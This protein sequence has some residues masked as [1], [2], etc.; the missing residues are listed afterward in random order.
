MFGDDRYYK[1][2]CLDVPKVVQSPGFYYGHDVESRN[3]R[4]VKINILEAYIWTSEWFR[5]VR[6]FF[7][8]TRR[9]PEPP[10]ENMGLIGP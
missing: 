4:Y 3:G 5:V 7:R 2:M 10:G 8:S 1:F 9:L 6:A